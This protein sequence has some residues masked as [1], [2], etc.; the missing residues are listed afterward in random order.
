MTITID[1]VIDEPSLSIFPSTPKYL[2]VVHIR[3][4]IH[5]YWIL[6][7]TVALTERVTTSL[8]A[9]SEERQASNLHSLAVYI[10]RCLFEFAFFYPKNLL[11]EF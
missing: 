8:E 7:K 1:F 3:E 10:P 4:M 2:S 9:T 5:I 11:T 6:Q